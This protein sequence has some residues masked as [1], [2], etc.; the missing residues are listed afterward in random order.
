L[1]QTGPRYHIQRSSKIHATL[2]QDSPWGY[3]IKA[4]MRDDASL[5][6][7]Y[8]NLDENQEVF[9]RFLAFKAAS[10]EL[11]TGYF[12]LVCEN[13]TQRS[14]VGMDAKPFGAR[15]SEERR[16]AQDLLH[17]YVKRLRRTT[18]LNLPSS[19]LTL[20]S[21]VL[22]NSLSS[23]PEQLHTSPANRITPVTRNKTMSRTPPSAFKHNNM[24]N[25]EPNHE[26]WGLLTQEGVMNSIP[27]FHCDPSHEAGYGPEN[28]HPGVHCL[29]QDATDSVGAVH[30]Q[31][32]VFYKT[33]ITDSLLIKGRLTPGCNGINIQ[34]PV[35]SPLAFS[36]IDKM[37]EVNAS[38]SFVPVDLSSS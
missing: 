38:Q 26:M 28:N 17:V 34:V 3:L 24:Q 33:T 29:I 14:L 22:V 6:P 35:V 13:T 11:K 5:S 15:G 19:F 30:R 23:S 20:D 25:T 18:T 32:S 37:N 27:L 1:Q 4:F 31:M 9:I 21:A 36:H 2:P 8:S 16:S 7:Q 10:R 12:K